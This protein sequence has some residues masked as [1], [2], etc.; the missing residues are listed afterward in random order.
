M[1]RVSF[2]LILTTTLFLSYSCTRATRP[3]REEAQKNPVVQEIMNEIQEDSNDAAVT[4]TNLPGSPK[5]TQTLH[6]FIENSGSMN[7]Y[8]NNASDFQM[9][10]GRAIQLM[11]FRYDQ[12]N[13]KTYYINTKVSERVRPDGTDLYAFVQ[14]MLERKEFTKTGG[15]ASTDL[16]DIV[17]K[18]LSY[19]D[20]N[21]TAI[22]ISDFIYSLPST[23]GVTTSLLYGCQNLTMSAFLE[24]TKEM[25]KGVSLATNLVQL[26]S[27]FDGHYWHWEKPTGKDYVSLKCS[28]PYY[29]CILG[30]DNNVREINSDKGIVIQDLK[31]YKNQFTISNKDVSRANYTVFDTKYKKGTYKH[32]T[33]QDEPIHA[34][35]HA[36]ANNVNEFELGVAI[37]LS[38]F[39]MSETDKLD[40]ANY[41]VFGNYRIVSIEEINVAKLTSPIDKKLIE[42]YHCTHAIVLACTGFPNDFSISIKRGLPQ[43]VLQ[44]SSTD[45][46]NI[47][48]DESEQAKTFGLSYFVEGIAD[49]YKHLDKDKNNFMTMNV[50]VKCK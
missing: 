41:E 10:V 50:S 29:L 30:T 25:P 40:K 20:E 22:L 2:F 3:I 37:D 15:T 45:D 47:R 32:S 46:R 49:A 24:K 34:I 9:A 12:E 27:Y 14:E 28:R 18:V 33:N 43:W 19:V 42:K 16:N 21:N 26:Y 13:I 44:S 23:K 35:T 6:V 4:N 17:K 8:I 31:G 48:D 38:D 11:K 1:K 7:G 36:K 5:P 39:S